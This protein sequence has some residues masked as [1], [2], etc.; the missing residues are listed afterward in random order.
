LRSKPFLVPRLSALASECIAL[1]LQ[2]SRTRPLYYN[3][4]VNLIAGDDGN[5]A[6]AARNDSGASHHPLGSAPSFRH[7]NGFAGLNLRNPSILPK[8]LF[9]VL[10]GET[11]SEANAR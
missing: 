2:V 4:A 7:R 1:R 11:D 9:D 8:M 10:T 5:D 3:C 6:D